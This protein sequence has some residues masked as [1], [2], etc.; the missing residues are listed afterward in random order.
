MQDYSNSAYVHYDHTT[1][2][3]TRADRHG[4]ATPTT[5]PHMAFL[6]AMPLMLTSTACASLTATFVRID[7]LCL[8]NDGVLSSHDLCT[9]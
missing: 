2:V 4:T 9:A 1:T 5:L 3:P 7:T 6:S 8:A